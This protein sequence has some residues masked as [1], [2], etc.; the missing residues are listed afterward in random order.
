M[1]GLSVGFYAHQAGMPF[2]V[3]EAQSTI[4][5]NCRTI[6]HDGFRFDSGAHRFHDKDAAQ[7]R[8]VKALLGKDIQ[9]IT[10][11]S[12][13]YHHGRLIAFPLALFDLARNLGFPVLSKAALE[14]LRARLAPKDG[15]GD[16]ETFAVRTYGR[17][18]ADLF[19]LGYSEKLWGVPPRRLSPV[20]SGGRLKG[21]KPTTVLREM[22]SR[23]G[24]KAKHL[25]GSFYYPREGIMAIPL[26]LAEAF[27]TARIQTGARVTRVAHD[28]QTING[29]EVNGRQVRT[30]G[31]VVS[32]LAVTDFLGMLDPPPPAAVIRAASK[33]RFRNLLLCALAIDKPSVTS[34]A[35][36]YFPDRDVPFSRVY[37]PKNRSTALSSPDKTALVAEYPCQPEDD[38]WGAPDRRIVE[39]TRSVLIRAGLIRSR[40]VRGAVV[41]RME[42]AYPVIERGSEELTRPV[43]RYLGGFENLTLSG[44]GGRFEYVHMHDLLKRGR[45]IVDGWRRA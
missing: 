12:R 8:V 37:E 29:V 16:F 6:A 43:F 15:R 11:P 3:F 39:T 33:L 41:V 26:R 21:L 9:E 5:G 36:I 2:T 22:F 31:R 35:S 40:E 38:V 13:I 18:I 17:T 32:T 19:L 25:D 23:S 30:A 7:T 44:R 34:C 27:G 14:V 24:F 10:S 4:G 45:E 42:S 1:A 20:V 28:G